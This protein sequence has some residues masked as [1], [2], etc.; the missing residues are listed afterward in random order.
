ME[1]STMKRGG[2]LDNRTDSSLILDRF[3]A[4]RIAL[5]RYFEN[6]HLWRS[7]PNVIIHRRGS[8]TCFS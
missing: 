4:E 6:L 7:R 5:R 8:D 3:E 1:W 2:T